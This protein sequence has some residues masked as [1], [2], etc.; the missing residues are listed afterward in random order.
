MKDR[1]EAGKLICKHYLKVRNRQCGLGKERLMN[2]LLQM[3]I[4]ALS[5]LY[6]HMLS[7]TLCHVQQLL[8]I[9]VTVF[10]HGVSVSPGSRH[11]NLQHSLGSLRYC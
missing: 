7:L 2:E 4:E 10:G 11:M 8:R 9:L 6:K 3:P 5:Q 1:S